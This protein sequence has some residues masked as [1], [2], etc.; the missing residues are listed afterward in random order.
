MSNVFLTP[1]ENAI[2]RLKEISKDY[3]IGG[4]EEFDNERKEALEIGISAIREN[5]QLQKENE[6]LIE[7]L[8]S[9]FADINHYRKMAKISLEN[10]SH[11]IF[12]S[13]E[14]KA[15]NLV[16][17][18]I[19][20]NIIIDGNE[21]LTENYYRFLNGYELHINQDENNSGED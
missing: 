9:V 1:E 14:Q 2:Y 6:K 16:Q 3:I 8:I 17:E 11:C 10:E 15:F 18:S 12:K 13:G 20:K 7:G 4:D 5:K 21:K 19:R